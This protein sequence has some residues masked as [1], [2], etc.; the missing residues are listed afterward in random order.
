MCRAVMRM[1]P[2]RGGSIWIGIVMSLSRLRETGAPAQNTQLVRSLIE[3]VYNR[4]YGAAI[5]EHYPDICFRADNAGGIVAAAGIRRASE[6]ALFLEQYLD[7]PIE[8]VIRRHTDESVSRSEIVEIG[9]LV[10]NQTGQCRSFFK[11]LCA[12]LHGLGFR[13]A[14]AT[15]T[16]PLRRIFRCSG[17]D[18]RFLAFADPA[19]L[20]DAGTH[21]GSYYAADPHVVFG[22]VM[23]FQASLERRRQEGSR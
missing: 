21:W 19:R 1:R 9:N 7:A 3:D 5:R 14:T 15:A 12:E 11:L 23:D 6:E 20:P 8:E 4:T 10:S 22:N 13:Y 2:M 18:S 16:R 17:F